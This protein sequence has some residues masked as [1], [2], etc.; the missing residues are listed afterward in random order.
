M[1]S[2][3]TIYKFIC[4][5]ESH[6]LFFYSNNVVK[7][8]ISIQIFGC[9]IFTCNIVFVNHRLIRVVNYTT[10]K[11][12]WHKPAKLNFFIPLPIIMLFFFISRYVQ[13]KYNFVFSSTSR[14]IFI[15]DMH[16]IFNNFYE[17]IKIYKFRTIFF[18]KKQ[19]G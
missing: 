15:D 16:K 1:Y 4:R 7:F 8:H 13:L 2:K 6:V 18:L 9:E 3:I 5:S 10:G 19:Q 11:N 17:K 12:K 14:F